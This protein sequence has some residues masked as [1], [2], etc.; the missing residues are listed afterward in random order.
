[1]NQ[2]GD[3]FPAHLRNYSISSPVAQIPIAQIPVAQ[4][5]IPQI[6]ITQHP[7]AQ[8]PIAQIPIAQRPIAQNSMTTIYVDPNLGQNNPSAGTAASPFRTITYALQQAKSGTTI[9]LVASTYSQQTGE[10]FPLTM[11]EGVILRGDE[12]QKG[13]NV[14]IVGGGTRV[15]PTFSGQNMTIWAGRSTQIR[16]ITVTNKNVRGTG[17]WL[18]SV[19]PV[20]ENCTFTQNHREG[21]FVTGTSDPVI[22]NNV[23]LANGGNGISIANKAKGQVRDNLFQNTG[24]GLAIGGDST[25]V[26]DKNR[27]IQN[28][29]GAYLNG[30]ARPVFRNNEIAGNQ[31]DGIV[32]TSGANPDLGNAASPGNNVFRDNGQFAINNGTSLQIVAYGDRL[33]FKKISGNVDLTGST[34][35]SDSNQQPDQ[36]LFPDI[37]GHWAQAYIEALAKRNVITGFPDGTF[38][39][40]NPVT[41]VQFASILTRAFAPAAKR[42]AIQFKDVEASFW[43]YSFIQTVVQG[44]FMSGYPEG[45]F[46]PNQSIPR[47]QVLVSLASGLDYGNGN[48]SILSKYQDAAAIPSWANGYVSAAT[49][50]R[51]VVNYPNLAQ[52]NPNRESSRAEVAAFVYQALV[53]AGKADPIASAYIVQP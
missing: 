39:P 12:T 45:V 22:I 27:I 43:G 50:R 40:N 53:N 16:G 26:I 15:S 24:F 42:P 38:Q 1:M 25:P 18:E 11:P 31:R 3:F 19:S 51:V 49:Q 10:T 44:G 5:P 4:I 13:Q 28:T 7:I 47:V 6:P 20:I 29:D 23:F 14:V 21:I 37:K 41:R 9:Q 2:P 17:I 52:L 8:I 33:D 35:V 30:N 34:N 46:Q 32:I 36:P 48:V